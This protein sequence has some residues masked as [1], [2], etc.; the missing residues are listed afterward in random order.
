[1]QGERFADAIGTKNCENLARD[2]L[3]VEIC[4]E[5]APRY[6]DVKAAA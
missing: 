3:Q 6:A 1:M 5:T 4:N 2:D